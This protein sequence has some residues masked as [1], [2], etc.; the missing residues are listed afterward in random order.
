MRQ[1]YWVLLVFAVW[2][3]S[4][5]A[6]RLPASEIEPWATFRGNLARTGNT[7]GLAGPVNPKILWVLKSTE[8]FIAAPVPSGNRLYV[9]GL[10][11][12]NV[13]SVHALNTGS[14]TKDRVAWTKT[15]PTLKLPIVSSPA[16]SKDVLVFGDGMHQTDG[17]VL[18]ALEKADGLSL[19]Q[20]SIPGALVHLEGSPT[21]TGGRVFVGAGD[22]GVICVS[23]DK[24]MLDGQVRELGF[25]RNHLKAKWQELLKQN[26]EDK[27]KD[28][29]FTPPPDED[30]LPTPEPVKI[31]QEGSGQ[32]HVDAPV[33]VVDERVLVGSSFLDKEKRGERA[34]FCLDGAHGT[35]RWKTPLRLNPW[36]GPSVLGDTVIL[37]SSTIGYEPDA[38]K[39]AKGEITALHLATGEVKWRRE[40]AGG[41]LSSVALADGIAVAAC[42]DGEI[43]A[44]D[45]K[46]GV[47][48]WT[49][50][51]Q[52]PF[53]APP[54]IAGG[55]VY[56][57]D[58]A[59]VIHA[60][61]LAQGKPIW[62]LDLRRDPKVA[63]SGMVYG[64][65]VV[66]NHRLFVATCDVQGR[67]GRATVVA[68]I[69][70]R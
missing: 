56:S 46:T 67:G 49:Y 48:R 58:L 15:T 30:K 55:I 25:V 53:F 69:G 36:G 23:A 35:V 65:P 62:K 31:W 45:I 1:R 16:V 6:A 44:F 5:F 66:D 19:W 12:F 14:S 39:S 18:H 13:S 51:D 11:T 7:D 63:A 42:T 60:V 28:P 68:C 37:G 52:A 32:W 34:A 61:S 20:L 38:V 70:D 41:I 24:A 50:Q 2:W 40:I 59:G 22:G 3:A 29:D 64:G 57:G 27:R 43:R 8:N 26:A 47:P 4:S 10:G 21:V 54:A 17:A 9:S 33:A